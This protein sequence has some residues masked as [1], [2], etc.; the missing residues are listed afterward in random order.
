MGL[1]DWLSNSISGSM[2]FWLNWCSSLL[3]ILFSFCGLKYF[4][5]ENLRSFEISTKT[6]TDLQ[7]VAT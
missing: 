4:V 1:E 7:D 5:F 6:G 3:F 2:S